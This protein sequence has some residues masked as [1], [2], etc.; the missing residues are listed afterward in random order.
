MRTLFVGGPGR[1]GTSFIAD[2]LGTHPEISRF[3]G[4]E[5]K[6]FTEKNGLLDLWHALGERYSPNRAVVAL[7]Q[8][9][10]M[11]DALIDGQYGQPAFASLAPAEDWRALF[12]RFTKAFLTDG[13]PRP[14]S[15]STFRIAARRLV[16]DLAELAGQ[17]SSPGEHNPKRYF[18]EKTPH[19]LLAADFLDEVAPGATFVHVMRDPRSI[20]HSLLGM[21]WGPDSLE[22]SAVWVSSYCEAWLRAE[23][24]AAELGLWVQRLHIEAIAVAPTT[25]ASTVCECLGIDTH[26]NLFTHASS[27]VLNG[28]ADTADPDMLECLRQRLHG[29]IAHFNYSADEVG[30]QDIDLLSETLPT[31]SGSS[32][33][34]AALAAY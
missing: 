9:H 16:C 27:S 14:S 23:A 8:F 19:A 1:S 22:Q 10:R 26:E 12:D 30:V 31:K 20:A 11:T 17:N 32:E 18:L 2:R 4:V 21:R 33:G 13:H 29:W 5:L 34:A 28:W 15:R 6:L 24:R 7:Q 3:K 25:W